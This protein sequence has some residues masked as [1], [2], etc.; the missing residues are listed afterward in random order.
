MLDS[1]KTFSA[2]AESALAAYRIGFY[3]LGFSSCS[4]DVR[5]DNKST[6]SIHSRTGADVIGEDEENIYLQLSREKYITYEPKLVALIEA[7]HRSRR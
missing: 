4:A 2:V 7:R 6:L 5:K 1:N 3:D